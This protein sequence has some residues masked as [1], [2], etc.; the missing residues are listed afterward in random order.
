MRSLLTL[1]AFA[2]LI[3]ACNFAAVAQGRPVDTGWHNE[4]ARSERIAE[5][6]GKRDD[7]LARIDA[8]TVHCPASELPEWGSA[9]AQ[10]KSALVNDCRA[11]AL[12]LD[13]GSPYEAELRALRAGQ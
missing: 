8:G 5:L 13:G 3:A 11:L 7:V 9:D 2:G 10:R 4:A 6:V 1:V 12:V